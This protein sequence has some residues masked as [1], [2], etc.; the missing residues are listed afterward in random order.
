MSRKHSTG[1]RLTKRSTQGKPVG[2]Q[3][4][5]GRLEPAQLPVVGAGRGVFEFL[6]ISK[7]PCERR[8]ARLIAAGFN[9]VMRRERGPFWAVVLPA[10]A[11]IK[12]G[13]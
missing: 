4:W 6:L 9:T 5:M 8:S 2:Y 10:E 12:A 1:S 13:G 3:V 7:K 11:E